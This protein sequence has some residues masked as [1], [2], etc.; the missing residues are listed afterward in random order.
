VARTWERLAKRYYFLGIRGVIKEIIGK[1]DI[2]IR[3]KVSRYAS[4]SIIQSLD[5]PKTPYISIVLDFIVK[6]LLSQDLITRI[7]YNSI[8]VVIDR[9]IKYIYMILY[10]K[11]SIAEDLAYMFLRVIIANYNTLE[12]MIS[13]KDKFFI[14]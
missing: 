13:D 1:Y 3:N 7:K 12:K 9:L 11:T 8:L 4:Y 6:L 2:Y 10:L 5:I 14:L